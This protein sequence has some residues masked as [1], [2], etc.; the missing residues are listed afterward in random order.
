MSS[1]RSEAKQQAVFRLTRYRITWGGTCYPLLVARPDMQPPPPP[2]ALRFP[3][4]FD[5]YGHFL[6]LPLVLDLILPLP[7]PILMPPAL[8]LP[9]TCQR[10]L[11]LVE[12]FVL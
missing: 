4:F 11:G 2:P 10:L 5:P 1:I 9:F 3:L 7:L 8:T 6:C 12:Y